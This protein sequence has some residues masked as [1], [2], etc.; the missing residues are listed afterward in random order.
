[1]KPTV[2]RI[3]HFHDHDQQPLAAMVVKVWNEHMVDLTV[4]SEGGTTYARTSIN[5]ESLV[6]G[7]SEYLGIFWCWPPREE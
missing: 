5:H 4:F 6:A 7:A 3:V 1:M 2:G